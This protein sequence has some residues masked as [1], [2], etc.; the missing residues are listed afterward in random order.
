MDL[1]NATAAGVLSAFVGVVTWMIVK[2]FNSDQICRLGRKLSNSE[3]ARYH[4]EFLN[5]ELRKENEELKVKVEA[6]NVT[7]EKLRA[8]LGGFPQLE[9]DS[10]EDVDNVD[11]LRGEVDRFRDLLDRLERLINQE[12]GNV[13]DGRR[14]GSYDGDQKIEEFVNGS[15]GGGMDSS[16]RIDMDEVQNLSLSSLS[17]NSDG[18]G[19]KHPSEEDMAMRRELEE[20]REGLSL[21]KQ[22]IECLQGEV[23]Q[24]NEKSKNYDVCLMNLKEQVDGLVSMLDKVSPNGEYGG[25][26]LKELNKNLGVVIDRVQE[27]ENRLNPLSSENAMD[28]IKVAIASLSDK[29]QDLNKS[30]E[31]YKKNPEG[32]SRESGV[33]ESSVID[34]E[35]AYIKMLEGKLALIDEQHEALGEQFDLFMRNVEEEV[36][37]KIKGEIDELRK[38]LEDDID[39]LRKGGGCDFGRLGDSVADLCKKV[40]ELSCRVDEIIDTKGEVERREVNVGSNAVD[41]E[42]SH[43]MGLSGVDGANEEEDI[44]DDIT[45]V[46]SPDFGSVKSV[47]EY[48]QRCGVPRGVDAV[49]NPVD[50]EKSH[51][52]VDLY[53]VDDASERGEVIDGDIAGE[54]VAFEFEEMNRWKSS[55]EERIQEVQDRTFEDMDRWKSSVE[56][57]IQGVQNRT[58]EDMDRWRS[59]V[60]EWIQGI[61]GRVDALAESNQ[62]KNGKINEIEEALFSEFRQEDGEE[63]TEEGVSV[64]E[65]FMETCKGLGV[66]R[67]NCL[68]FGKRDNLKEL[69]GECQGEHQDLRGQLGGLEEQIRDIKAQLQDPKQ[70]DLRGECQGEHQ[71]LRR[72][73]GGLE[74]QIRDIKAQLQ[75][76]KQQAA[77]LEKVDLESVIENVDSHLGVSQLRASVGTIGE[78]VESLID[79]VN[80]M[81]NSN[82]NE[83]STENGKKKSDEVISSLV[84]PFQDSP[85]EKDEEKAVTPQ[86]SPVKEDVGSVSS[87]SAEQNRGLNNPARLIGSKELDEVAGYVCS[88]VNCQLDSTVKVKNPLVYELLKIEDDNDIHGNHIKALEVLFKAMR[89]DKAS[90]EEFRSL[91]KRSSVEEEMQEKIMGLYSVWE[92]VTERYSNMCTISESEYPPHITS[93]EKEMSIY[94]GW[95][96]NGGYCLG[97]SL[98]LYE[99]KDWNVV[100]K[101]LEEIEKDLKYKEVEYVDLITRVERGPEINLLEKWNEAFVNGGREWL[102]RNLETRL[103]GVRAA[104]SRF[105]T[106][107]VS[108]S[109]RP[110]KYVT[111]KLSYFERMK[112]AYK[113]KVKGYLCEVSSEASTV[114]ETQ[115]GNTDQGAFGA[116]S[117]SGRVSRTEV[118]KKKNWEIINE[119]E[120]GLLSAPSIV[121]DLG[122]SEP[123]RKRKYMLLLDSLRGSSGVDAEDRVEIM[124]Q[125]FKDIKYFED[126]GEIIDLAEIFDGIEDLSEEDYKEWKKCLNLFEELRKMRQKATEREH[127]PAG[128]GFGYDGLYSQWSLTGS[129]LAQIRGFRPLDDDEEGYKWLTAM[130]RHWKEFVDREQLDER[131]FVGR[132]E[133]KKKV[134]DRIRE[135]DINKNARF[136]K[137]INENF[138]EALKKKLD[139]EFIDPDDEFMKKDGSVFGIDMN[140]YERLVFFSGMMKELKATIGETVDLGKDFEGMSEDIKKK[141][142]QYKT[143]AVGEY[144]LNRRSLDS[145]EESSLK[146]KED[147]LLLYGEWLKRMEPLFFKLLLQELEFCMENDKW[148]DDKFLMEVTDEIKEE[149]LKEWCLLPEGPGD[150]KSDHIKMVKEGRKALLDQLYK[151][152]KDEISFS[153][154]SVMNEE[155]RR[156]T[157]GKEYI[158]AAGPDVKNAYTKYKKL[159][160]DYFRRMRNTTSSERRSLIFDTEKG[161]SCRVLPRRWTYRYEVLYTLWEAAE[162]RC[163]G[164]IIEHLKNVSSIKGNNSIEFATAVEQTYGYF[165]KVQ[166]ELGEGEIL[167][168]EKFNKIPDLLVEEYK[169]WKD[170]KEL[171]DKVK[172]MQEGGRPE[173]WKDEYE[174]LYESYC[175]ETGCFLYLMRNMENNVRV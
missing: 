135:V 169:R 149:S 8:M 29:V 12:S 127:R 164:A 156:K 92:G 134:I 86:I 10:L 99:D 108:E 44:G 148:L 174:E 35:K 94:E 15:S 175:S 63:M 41:S 126:E 165:E 13:G 73:L 38:S 118:P 111:N 40:G 59:S 166:E 120:Q 18:V 173:N 171:F 67:S 102:E 105:D 125:A 45:V 61:Q 172:G 34:V 124:E 116:R 55:V 72:Q 46:E 132:I 157:T 151:N 43:P 5:N 89:G 91:L 140:Y 60:E 4:A 28:G 153:F 36:D 32:Y 154:D 121:D 20:I 141:Y 98:S 51:P 112:L 79:A 53:S 152:W 47:D 130:L 128:W 33:T 158:D 2:G 161:K 48:K 113:D 76:P 78:Q 54:K 19:A 74:E 136:M 49:S 137:Y 107:I 22:K 159:R 109:R 82:G 85:L 83:S 66:N 131:A 70:Q 11:R 39:K 16:Q 1:K 143:Q 37:A 87:L 56:E 145:I 147:I 3:G 90:E 27:I 117:Q 123:S 167:D 168:L 71:D 162:K 101:T 150:L 104:A 142:N 17:L 24:N 97:L 64:F 103:K 93:D 129:F 80:S 57:R 58:F 88:L 133:Q 163:T 138:V 106:G 144:F 69:R 52:A 7:N 26:D 42:K 21:Q 119:F 23:T 31:E 9:R 122:V 62:K 139:G 14:R 81:S 65:M 68:E 96:E 95:L 6:L 75:D 50:S 100:F 155:L 170:L 25:L 30:F 146:N 115:R 160:V 77:G 114:K 110:G 84:V